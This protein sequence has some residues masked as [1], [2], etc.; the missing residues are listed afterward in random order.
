MSFGDLIW[1]FFIF[2]AIQPMLQQK[3][4]EAMRVRKISQLE[5]ERKSRVIL[6][7]HRQETMRFLGFPVARY[8]DIND[9]EEVLRAIQMT[10]A[11][12]PLDLVLHTPGGLVL[13]A[14]QIGKASASTRPGSRSLY[15]TTPCPVAP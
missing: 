11:D 13:A 10:D 2:S 4:L 3:M 8:I 15:P 6:L 9:S 1:L 7:V 12:V 5:R 14:L